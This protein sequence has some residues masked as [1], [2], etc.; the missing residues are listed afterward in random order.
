LPQEWLEETI[1][2]YSNFD[3]W[4]NDERAELW[5]CYESGSPIGLVV[6]GQLRDADALGSD[7]E[8]WSIYFRQKAKGR[9]Y[10][11]TTLEFAES[12]LKEK[13]CTKIYVWCLEQNK[14]ARN[15][16][17]NKNNYQATSTRKDQIL[18]GVP[19]NEIRFEKELI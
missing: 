2:N 1:A 10:A 7:G 8:I 14:R 13:G 12:K 5:L 18:A 19:Y 3:K 9:G 11:K 16:Y 15:F 17:E 6:F 4:I